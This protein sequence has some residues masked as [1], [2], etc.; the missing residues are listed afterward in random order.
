MITGLLRVIYAYAPG[1]RVPSYSG[2]DL[3]SAIHIG[4]AIVCACLPTLWP[5]VSRADFFGSA[6]SSISR[7]Y[8]DLRGRYSKSTSTS[9]PISES[10]NEL[11]LLEE[12]NTKRDSIRKGGWMHIREESRTRE[13]EE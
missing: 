3:W 6:R 7:R 5:L 4:M 2:A 12:T 8:N 11:A 1:S 13:I 10:S 9:D